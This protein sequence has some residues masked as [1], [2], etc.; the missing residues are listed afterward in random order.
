MTYN[1]AIIGTGAD[2][3]ERDRDGYAM[4]Y[5][6]AP[7]Y[8]RLDECNLIACADIVKE[9]AEAFADNFDLNHVYTDHEKLLRECDL[10]IVSVCVPPAV[11]AEI[12]T[13]CTSEGDLQAIHCEKPM[14]TTWADCQ[15][16][17]EVCE[18]HGVQLTIDHQ[19]RLA[20][21]AQEA[22]RIVDE[23]T[24]G[25]L[26]RVEWSEVNLFDAGSH[27]FDLCDYITDG[28]TPEWVLAGIDT[29]PNNE[30]FG[31]VNEVQAIAQ[32]GYED[33]TQGVASTGEGNRP[34]FIDAYLR[35]V[36]EDGEIEIEPD[37]GPQIRVRT[38]GGW[39]SVDTDNETIFNPR[40][41]LPELV[42]NKVAD[43]LPL[44]N[45]Q[46]EEPPTHYERA[47]EHV[48]N[49]LQ[50]GT[51]PL[52]AGSNV[53]RGTE[54]VFACWESARRGERV[55]LPLD[56]E[57]NPLKEILDQKSTSESSPASEPLQPN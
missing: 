22:K 29:D 2:P 47:I 34:T 38:D 21:P 24:I 16:M 12:V 7:G 15:E 11:H 35:L 31:T 44:I 49:S 53:L 42:V 51:E 39:E 6:H 5:R 41:T 13:D 30:W 48:V 33:G 20:K 28:A 50:E 26:R 55:E 36:G 18:R 19:R 40:L 8:I 37:D 17:V 23:G 4:A 10:D 54:L 32:W 52:L 46:F 27:L 9:N 57:G 3:D 14:A 56:I 25:E 43:T 1:V 45:K